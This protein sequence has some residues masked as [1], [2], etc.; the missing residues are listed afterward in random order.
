M[1]IRDRPCAMGYVRNNAPAGSGATKSCP[2]C[3]QGCP[4][5]GHQFSVAPPVTSSL[6]RLTCFSPP[7]RAKPLVD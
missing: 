4:L 2:S 7:Q 1:C 5:A 6:I 3:C